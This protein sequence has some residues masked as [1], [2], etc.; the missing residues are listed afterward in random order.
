MGGIRANKEAPDADETELPVGEPSEIEGRKV[1]LL[2]APPAARWTGVAFREVVE[3]KDVEVPQ[4]NKTSQ[5]DVSQVKAQYQP[6]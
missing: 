6:F 1:E 2:G 4:N 5:R 3:V